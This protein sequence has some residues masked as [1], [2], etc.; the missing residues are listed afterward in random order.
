MKTPAEE[1]TGA[2]T[3]ASNRVAVLTSTV[4]PLVVHAEGAKSSV[5]SNWK[6]TSV[7]SGFFG[8]V[9]RRYPLLMPPV[10][11]SFVGTSGFR[12]KA[13]L[14]RLGMPSLVPMVESAAAPLLAVVPNH[15]N[16]QASMGAKV[17]KTWSCPALA[18]K[19]L[20]AST[21]KG[22]VVAPLKLPGMAAP[23]P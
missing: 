15:C 12:P 2:L 4:V 11:G 21:R 22:Y 7:A 20:V 23:E 3:C 18:P 16:R 8:E 9:R 6:L 13:Y 14:S 19:A 10:T 5:S 17:V 1:T